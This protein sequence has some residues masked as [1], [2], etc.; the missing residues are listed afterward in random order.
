MFAESALADSVVEECAILMILS[1]G[2]L[3]AARVLDDE[4]NG[5]RKPLRWGKQRVPGKGLQSHFMGR[6]SLDSNLSWGWSDR[7][8]TSR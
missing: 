3:A 5:W 8:V 6:R 2:L 1:S 4:D 7:F